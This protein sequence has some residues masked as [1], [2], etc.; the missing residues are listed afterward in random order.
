MGVSIA[1]VMVNAPFF[2]SFFPHS[3][4]CWALCARCQ[5]YG[6]VVPAVTDGPRA[7]T[8][9]PAVFT[10]TKGPLGASRASAPAEKMLPSFVA[11][12]IANELD[13]RSSEL[14]QLR[15]NTELYSK[16]MLGAKDMVR[17][18]NSPRDGRD[19][20]GISDSSHSSPQSR[21]NS[22]S[23]AGAATVTAAAASAA[24]VS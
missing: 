10:P 21:R 4:R 17:L 3:P 22:P 7:A 8:G 16:L 2:P 14:R 20:A 24:S 11:M 18:S 9:A 13:S 1:H 23:G 15:R 12:R 19:C 5:H 6:V